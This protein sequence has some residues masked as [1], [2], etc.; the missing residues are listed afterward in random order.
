MENLLLKIEELSNLL[1]SLLPM[2]PEWQSKLDKK[3]RLEFNYNSNHIEGNTL[4]Y[5]ETELLLIFGR[6]K[7]D[8]TIQEHDEMKAHDVA[9]KLIKE[10]A[11]NNEHPITEIDIKNLNKTILVQPFWKD[12][13]TPD[14]QKTQRLIK[15][16]NYKE[17]PN[18]VILKNGET[19]EY[20]SVTDTPILM[21]EL[22]EWYRNEESKKELHP[23]VLAALMHYKI[24]RIHPFDD[25]NGRISRLLMNYVLFKNNMPPVIIKSIDKN[26]YLAA[27]NSAD[28]GDLD[29]F[30]KYIA[31]QLIWSLELSVRAAKEED[32]EEGDDLDK[33]IKLLKRRLKGED[34]IKAVKNVKNISYVLEN[35]IFP[36]FRM[37]EEKCSSFNEFFME[38]ARI[39]GYQSEGISATQNIN[40][41]LNTWEQIYNNWYVPQFKS[42][43]KKLR[44]LK[45]E[46][47][48][49]GFKK[50]VTANSFQINLEIY[51]NDYNYQILLRDTGNISES[52]PYSEDLNQ[53]EIEKI[54]KPLIKS[55]I[56]KIKIAS[57]I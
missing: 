12:A 9:L 23:V 25:G 24:V 19:F 17:L 44:Y 22:I 16:G 11:E 33:E 4:T 14:G 21:G 50:T 1:N 3:F 20:A 40:S 5:G 45:Y 56:E 8:H 18:S 35:N 48:L 47:E 55:I 36:I 2:K 6:T 37:I 26:N 15:V 31:K 51:F 13:I 29:S 10:W 38:M 7:N 53:L 42:Q 46:Y 28:T 30:I 49:K 41:V 57:G 32:L 43:S 34:I 39:V 27:L 54:V 52:F